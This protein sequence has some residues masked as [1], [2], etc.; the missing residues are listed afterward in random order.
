MQDERK[1]G[2]EMNVTPHAALNRDVLGSRA[3]P[4]VEDGNFHSSCFTTKF[5][6]ESV[7]IYF[8]IPRKQQ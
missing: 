1:H 6:L 2:R 5:E 4:G 3:I 8:L 7:D